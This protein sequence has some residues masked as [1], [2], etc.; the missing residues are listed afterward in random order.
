[1]KRKENGYCENEMWSLI[2]KFFN[3]TFI[4]DDESHFT[5]NHSTYNANGDHHLSDSSMAQAVNKFAT[6]AKFEDQILIW[7]VMRSYDLSRPFI[8]KSEF[9]VKEHD[10]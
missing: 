7:I 9:S 3:G 8:R 2:Q 4:L 6:K 5:F 10:V 1:M